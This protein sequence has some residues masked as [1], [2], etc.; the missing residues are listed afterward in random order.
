MAKGEESLR[1]IVRGLEGLMTL[2]EWEGTLIR[3]L[4]DKADTA[5]R[6]GMHRDAPPRENDRPSA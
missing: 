3:D 5:L 1:E 6:L 4:R 2:N